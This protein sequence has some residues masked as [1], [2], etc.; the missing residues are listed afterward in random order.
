MNFFP[1][2]IVSLCI[3]TSIMMASF[4]SSIITTSGIGFLSTSKTQSSTSVWAISIGSCTTY[5]QAEEL[6]E[7]VKTKNGGGV[8]F[9]KD[10]FY[11][12]A[13]AYEIEND[14]KKVQ[15]NL[16]EQNISSEIIKIEVPQTSI[17][18][19]YTISEVNVL[20]AG[21]TAYKESFRTLFDLSIALDTQTKSDIIIKEA[22]V[23][24][25]TKLTK[26]NE[27]FASYLN[28]KLTANLVA[29]VLQNERTLAIV[30]GLTTTNNSLAIELKSAYLNIIIG[31]QE[32]L[33]SLQTTVF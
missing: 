25:E 17:S 4:L 22:V 10:L 27:D 28:S 3:A 16:S 18:S 8:I 2:I 23:K 5:S 20:D 13:S 21:L 29:L 15:T 12:L 19:S 6:S 7:T 31:Q 32:M 24:L 1:I 30:K 26:I 33:E 14:A 11:V 9:K